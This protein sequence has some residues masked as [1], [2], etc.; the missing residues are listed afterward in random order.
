MSLAAAVRRKLNVMVAGIVLATIEKW[1]LSFYVTA[2][3]SRAA[4]HTL[5]NPG[6][7]IVCMFVRYIHGCVVRK[8]AHG[9]G[10]SLGMR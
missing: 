8:G 5:R 9:K 4:K 10:W 3:L 1:M 2:A 6:G 7:G